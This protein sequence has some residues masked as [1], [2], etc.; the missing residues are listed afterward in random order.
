[1]S[2]GYV[3][4]WLKLHHHWQFG[5]F[6]ERWEWLAQFGPPGV[7]DQVE[8]YALHLGRKHLARDQTDRQWKAVLRIGK[9]VLVG[10]A[11]EMLAQLLAAAHYFDNPAGFNELL[12]EQFHRFCLDFYQ[13]YQL[14]EDAFAFDGEQLIISGYA[15]DGDSPGARR[16]PFTTLARR[17]Q[18]VQFV[19]DHAAAETFV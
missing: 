18:P 19:V 13:G 17:E 7:L 3:E 1:M 12:L 6:L 9:T 2:Q 10:P 5:A 14:R 16:F 4:N 8:A 15:Y 11:P